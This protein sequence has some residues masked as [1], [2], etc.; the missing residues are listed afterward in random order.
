L[1]WCWRID[2]YSYRWNNSVIRRV[3]SAVQLYLI[4][5]QF[6]KTY[7]SVGGKSGLNS[8]SPS[9]ATL[10]RKNG[11]GGARLK[12]CTF[13]ACAFIDG[14]RGS[15]TDISIGHTSRNHRRSLHIFY[16]LASSSIQSGITFSRRY[17]VTTTFEL[18]VFH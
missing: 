14:V 6:S 1:I 13:N 9:L 5:T 8:T 17:R 10:V 16:I 18:L 3:E 15:A 12:R 2:S 4:H 7:F 11:A